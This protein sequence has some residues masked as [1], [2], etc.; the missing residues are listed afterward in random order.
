M[1]VARGS[2]STWARAQ[3]LR[4]LGAVAQQQVGSSQTQDQPGDPCT[5]KRFSTTG[6]PG[7]SHSLPL[8]FTLGFLTWVSVSVLPMPEVGGSSTHPHHPAGRGTSHTSSTTPRRPPTMRGS[9]GAPIRP[10]IARI[11]PDAAPG[12]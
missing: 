11:H 2:H 8:N 9:G 6:P 5:G 4:L 1:V 10:A 3:Q 7:K 12:Q